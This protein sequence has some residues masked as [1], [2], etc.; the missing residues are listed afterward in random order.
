[1]WYAGGMS[2]PPRSQ[3]D[4]NRR[5]AMAKEIRDYVREEGSKPFMP[6][7]VESAKVFASGDGP[8]VVEVVTRSTP[9]LGQMTAQLAPSLPVA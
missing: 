1:M 5:K 9:E 4:R 2:L 8:T 3:E 7:E 6:V